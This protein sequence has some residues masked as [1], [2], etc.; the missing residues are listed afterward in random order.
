MVPLGDCC[1]TDPCGYW[2]LQF[3]KASYHH[4]YQ[5]RCAKIICTN[6][7]YAKSLLPGAG[8]G[9]VRT[10]GREH[11]PQGKACYTR[12]T[13]WVCPERAP[14]AF[15]WFPTDVTPLSSSSANFFSALLNSHSHMLS[16]WALISTN[17][18]VIWRPQTNQL[19]TS[20]ADISTHLCSPPQRFPNFL[21]CI[22]L[23]IGERVCHGSHV[24]IIRHL[25]QSVLSLHHVDPR[26]QTQVGQSWW[27]E[28]WPAE[29]LCQPLLAFFHLSRLLY[30][31]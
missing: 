23:F 13:G 24:A 19:I 4:S 12:T 2:E 1:E 6:M 28:S 10:P 8:H 16:L 15:A 14:E 21:K 3:W 25:Q 22:Y 20:M 9:Q 5:E 17:L 26:N 18:G 11:F 27:Q 30:N 29:P 7:M 31:L